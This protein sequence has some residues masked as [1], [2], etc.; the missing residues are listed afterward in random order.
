MDGIVKFRI[1]S[2]VNGGYHYDG[3]I[4]DFQIWDVAL[5]VNT[6]KEWMYK[7]I[8]ATH[9]AYQNLR[10]YYRFDEGTGLTATDASPNGFDGQMWG[11]PRWS[12]LFDNEGY[13]NYQYGN[14][15]L[16]WVSYK[17]H[18]PS[19]HNSNSFITQDIYEVKK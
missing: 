13:R 16:L 8:D 4:N 15:L 12:T 6:V 5:D 3:L 17:T 19:M 14:V 2:G 7:D 11:A 1:G 10:L 9:P 18:L